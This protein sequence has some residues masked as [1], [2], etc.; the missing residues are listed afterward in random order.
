M[1][2]ASIT[3]ENLLSFDTSTFNFKKYNVIVGP[4]GSGK[5]NLLRIIKIIV[6]G[7]NHWHD[8]VTEETKHTPWKK[9]QVAVTVETT[10]A[11]TRLILQLLF[12]VDIKPEQDLQPWMNFTIIMTWEK[13]QSYSDMIVYFQSGIVVVLR[14]SRYYI[15]QYMSSDSD[16]YNRKIKNLCQM[17]YRDILGT[18]MK[19]NLVNKNEINKYRLNINDIDKQKFIHNPPDFFTG[20][21]AE[22][23]IE[24]EER[25][26][27][28]RTKHHSGL[29]DYLSPDNN[30]TGMSS[31]GLGT[32]LCRIIQNNFI[33]VMEIHPNVDIIA[34]NLL[35]LKTENESGYMSLQSRFT[36]IFPDTKI[37]V[38]QHGKASG[39][40]V[41]IEENEKTYNLDNSASGYSEAIHILYSIAN[42]TDCTI[43]LDEPEIHF[44]PLRIRK[45]RQIL[46]QMTI[47]TGNQITVISHSPEFVERR[48]LTSGDKALTV[49]TKNNNK[50]VVA[51][52]K[53][54]DIKLKSHLIDPVMFFSNAVFLVEG[55]GDAVV[56]RAISDKYDGMFDKH[57]IAIVACGSYS[58]IKNFTELLNSYSITYYG[59]AD[60]EYKYNDQI[61]VLDEDLEHELAKTTPDGTLVFGKSKMAPQEAYQYVCE[62]LDTKDGF[63]RLK[64]TDIWASIQKVIIGQGKN[65]D[66]VIKES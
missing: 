31:I 17:E 9:S 38:E 51:S 52:P 6:S 28:R 3:I 10:N 30:V 39:P 36:E 22:C 57:G 41:W 24:G 40:V 29:L 27:S 44:H 13:D 8:I 37:K 16:D 5:T 61:T 60:K 50:S 35:K 55:P 12:D 14:S 19:Q 20:E 33:Q 59:L 47:Q 46:V 45:I 66:D 15:S 62:L 49:V 58:N 42:H 48:M 64:K 7:K 1:K 43:F 65:I 63:E 34:K 32:L 2:I 23:C 21:Y 56:I 26:M 11:E 25:Q 53:N 4:N 54:I 18:M